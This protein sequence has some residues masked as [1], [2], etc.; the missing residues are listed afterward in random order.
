MAVTKAE[1]VRQIR[2]LVIEDATDYFA[3]DDLIEWYD[4]GAALQ[5]RIFLNNYRLWEIESRRKNVK[6]IIDPR[7]H[8]YIKQFLDDDTFSTNGSV[9]YALPA[10][11][12][13][14]LSVSADIGVGITRPLMLLRV[15][16]KQDWLTQYVPHF[17]TNLDRFFYA[18][19]DDGMLNIYITTAD[20][21]PP[22]GLA[23]LTRYIRDVAKTIGLNVDLLDPFNNGPIRYAVGM[24]YADQG[25]DPTP[26]FQQ[27]ATEATAA[28]PPP[29]PPQRR[30]D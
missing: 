7:E 10:D 4:Q 27:H 21:I 13:K 1:V 14:L 23:I 22:A 17:K 30:G 15:P 24:A 19:D 29:P 6:I 16:F 5:H 28:L 26:W 9:A 12:M 11:L 25:I 3:D 8:D 2:V 18:V 20:T